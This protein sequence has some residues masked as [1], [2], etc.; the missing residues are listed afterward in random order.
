MDGVWRVERRQWSGKWRSGER[1]VESGWSGESRMESGEWTVY[2]GDWG[3]VECGVWRGDPN[4]K[5]RVGS[6]M[7]S[8]FVALIMSRL[9]H[10]FFANYPSRVDFRARGCHQVFSQL[11]EG[12]LQLGVPSGVPVTILEPPYFWKL[13]SCFWGRIWKQEHSL[14]GWIWQNLTS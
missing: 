11:Y 12:F 2:N 7:S 3:R 14:I 13:P 10:V 8:S 5:P 1:K 4:P 6:G 9:T